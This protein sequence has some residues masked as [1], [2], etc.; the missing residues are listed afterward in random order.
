MRVSFVNNCYLNVE[1]SEV[2]SMVLIQLLDMFVNL[3]SEVIDTPRG[4]PMLQRPIYLSENSLL[5][6]ATRTDP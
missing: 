4:K 3:V 6:S 1:P 2:R 5:S